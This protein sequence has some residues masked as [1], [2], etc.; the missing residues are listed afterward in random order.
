[1]AGVAVAAV[2]AV[3]VVAV[4]PA[5]AAND[6]APND[7]NTVIQ[8]LITAYVGNARFTRKRKKTPTTKKPAKPHKYKN[9][10][11]I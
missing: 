3:A 8:R 4:V 1:M 9:S 6:A 7:A 2:A 11:G 10:I 5:A